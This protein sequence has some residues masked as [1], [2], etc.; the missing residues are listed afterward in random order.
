MDIFGIEMLKIDT[1]NNVDICRARPESRID[2][3]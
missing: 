3:L 1:N 2:G